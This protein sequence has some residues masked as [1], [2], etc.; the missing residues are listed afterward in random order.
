MRLRNPRLVGASA[1]VAALHL[2]LCVQMYS[3]L[4]LP[5]GEDWGWFP[6]FVI[7]LPFSVL[8]L[9]VSEMLPPLLVFGLGGSLWWFALVYGFGRLILYLDTRASSPFKDTHHHSGN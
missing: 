3:Y 8:L 5:H 1:A 4:R 2:F 7:D 6:I 9:R